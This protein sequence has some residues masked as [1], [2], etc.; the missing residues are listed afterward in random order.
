[1]LLEVKDLNVRYGKA[2]ALKELNL[3]VDDGEVVALIGANGAGKTT[4]LRTISGLKAAAGGEID[5]LGER[6]DGVPAHEIVA[7]GIAHVPEGR[8]VFGPMTVIDNL[9]M[10]AYL[11]KDKRVVDSDLERMYTHFPRLKERYKQLAE[12]LSGGEQQMLAVARALMANPK[13]LLMDEPSMGLSP[14][15]VEEI[16]HIV[17]NIRESG[18]SVLLVEQNANLALSL[19]DR[20]YV[21]EVGAIILEGPAQEVAKNELVKKAYLGA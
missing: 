12:S 15:M 9:R 7:R 8:I 17:T 2:Q 18:V 11:R 10:G 21:L 13:L 3:Q 1:M 16:G 4:L 6:I 19:S 14:I 5:F 20:A